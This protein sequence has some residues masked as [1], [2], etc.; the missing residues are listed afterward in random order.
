MMTRRLFSNR[1]GGALLDRRPPLL[2]AM[3]GMLSAGFIVRR[4]RSVR[5]RRID[6]MALHAGGRWAAFEYDQ[7]FR[8][9]SISKMVTATGFMLLPP[10]TDLDADVSTY[11]GERLRHPA[12]PDIAITP[13]M[14]LSH[15][16]GLRN[17]EDF[18]VPFNHS[19]LARL[20]EA[21]GQEGHGGWFAPASER[22]GHWFSYS[23]TNFA[24]LAQI[25]E[26]VIDQRFDRYMRETLFD[27][28]ELDIG[29]NWS[30]VSQAKRDRAAAGVRWLEG[31]WTAEVDGNPPRAP[32]PALYRG[33][34]NTTSTEADYR[35]GENGFAFAPHGGLRLSLD[36]MDRLARFYLRGAPLAGEGALA[37]MS[38]PAWTFD[39][40]QPNGTTGNGWYQSFGL[41]VHL[42]L[43]RDTP[44][45]SPGDAFFGANSADWRGH[46]GDAYGLITGLLW[47]PRENAT[48]VYAINGMPETNR[49]PGARSA[50][51]APEE[52]IIDAAM[53]AI[54]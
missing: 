43:G 40:A 51:S 42:L 13:R 15:T 36:D 3:P 38:A 22:P 11:L 9:A 16:S 29:Y 5:R 32:A 14:L 39:P 10:G 23:D 30:G 1:L 6:G 25:I 19:L 53:A 7:P 50:M 46:F 47:N 48:L 24:V 41:G 21:T 17:G 52:A 26:R 31:A 37:Q 2:G 4:G 54:G 49:P 34:G 27:Q 44:G 35:V 20:N 33:A 18:P 28:L 8:I 45:A 12:F